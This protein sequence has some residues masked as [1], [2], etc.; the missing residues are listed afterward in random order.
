MTYIL[1]SLAQKRQVKTRKHPRDECWVKLLFVS[2]SDALSENKQ[3]SV[4]FLSSGTVLDI[5]VE[6]V[7]SEQLHLLIIGLSRVQVA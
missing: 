1:E 4:A 2:L 7:V 6:Q 5:A 3:R